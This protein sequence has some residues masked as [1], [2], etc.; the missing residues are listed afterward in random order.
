[1]KIFHTENGKEAVYVQMQDIMELNRSD[2]PILASIYMK[3]FK[4]IVI[5]D[6]TNRFDFV[7][8]DDEEEV[9]FFK[10]VDFIID[11]NE[12]K[13]MTDDQLE[14]EWG[15]LVTKSNEI[16]KKWNEMSENEREKNINLF[17]EYE[18]LKYM[19][20]F[21]KEIYAIKH[22]KMSMPFP[23]FVQ[24]PRMPKKK[25]FFEKIFFWRKE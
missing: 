3:V 25:S 10:E 14:N 15:K 4:G 8:F 1:M 22:N 16:A 11:Y 12:Y 23:E 7:R 18:N 9:K 21:L 5:V 20:N 17:Q 24:I 2:T 13:D 6:D 19:M